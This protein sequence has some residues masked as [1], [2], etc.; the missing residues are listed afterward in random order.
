M[1]FCLDGLDDRS[2]DEG[3]SKQASRTHL[4]ETNERDALDL[5]RV[6]I[7]REARTNCQEKS[8]GVSRV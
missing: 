8:E 4:L 1:L 6:D 5:D 3:A 2:D 7:V